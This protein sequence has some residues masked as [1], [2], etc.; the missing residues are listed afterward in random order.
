M[1]EKNSIIS[2]ANNSRNF[3]D[4]HHMNVSSAIRL[5]K[6]KLNALD[7]KFVCCLISLSLLFLLMFIFTSNIWR[8]AVRTSKK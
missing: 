2:S 7:R 4:L 5:L 3:V 6:E 8:L 1:E